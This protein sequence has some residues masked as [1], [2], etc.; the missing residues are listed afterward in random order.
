[1]SEI[2]SQL[3]MAR[4]LLASTD[5][6]IIRKIETGVEVYTLNQASS[7]S[8]GAN[9]AQKWMDEEMTRPYWNQDNQF[10]VEEVIIENI[11]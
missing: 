1:M 10:L 11:K 4:L 9:S 3:D 2:L 5:W 8:F 7:P 6:M